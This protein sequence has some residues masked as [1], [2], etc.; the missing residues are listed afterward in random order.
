MMKYNSFLFFRD[1]YRDIFKNNKITYKQSS[2]IIL[3]LCI[4]I[5]IIISLVPFYSNLFSIHG[6]ME[7]MSEKNDKM[8]ENINSIVKTQKI[9]KDEDKIV[10]IEFY[11][12]KMEDDSIEKKELK[13]TLNACNS[14][15]KCIIGLKKTVINIDNEKV[16][17]KNIEFLESVN[18]VI[19]NS[20]TK[21]DIYNITKIYIDKLEGSDEKRGLNK[22]LKDP[23]ICSPGDPN[24][25]IQAII[26]KTTEYINIKKTIETEKKSKVNEA[27]VA[28]A[29]NSATSAETSVKPV[30]KSPE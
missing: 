1:I 26:D 20:T 16:N 4:I 5:P 15:D 8:I 19:K 10:L 14:S 7:G 6:Y 22:I 11:V 18:N 23:E 2:F 12:N 27:K 24:S 28:S 13:K 17:T 9:S 25:C 21:I 3:F 29:S 30:P